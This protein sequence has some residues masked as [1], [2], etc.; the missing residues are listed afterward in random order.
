[1]SILY[2]EIWTHHRAPSKIESTSILFL[3]LESFN[4][5]WSLGE[6]D[7]LNICFQFFFVQF[8]RHFTQFSII[9]SGYNV[10]LVLFDLHTLMKIVQISMSSKIVKLPIYM[11]GG[12]QFRRENWPTGCQ[13]PLWYERVG[14]Q[15]GPPIKWAEP[16][17]F[18]ILKHPHTFYFGYIFGYHNTHKANQFVKCVALGWSYTN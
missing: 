11:F 3:L 17:V 18:F 15:F 8:L 2:I 6:F 10:K 7:P 9:E 5:P 16:L 4:F 12:K 14:G 1:M 13:K